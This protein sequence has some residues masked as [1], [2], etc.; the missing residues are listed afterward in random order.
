MKYNEL[1]EY[2]AQ[3]YPYED[4]CII[5]VYIENVKIDIIAK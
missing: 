5:D 4:A 2:H 3:G 1:L